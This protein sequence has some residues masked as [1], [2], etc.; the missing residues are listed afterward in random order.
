MS[1]SVPG[2]QLNLFALPAPPSVRIALDG[3]SWMEHH[4]GWLAQDASALFE[5]L[6][7]LPLWE[8]RRRWMFTREV[9]EPR[10]TA[11]FPVLATAPVAEV[12]ELGARLSAQYGVAYDSAWLNLYRTHEDSTAW[13]A[14]RAPRQR[15]TAVV[16]VLS[17]GASRRFFIRPR[18]GGGRS[19]VLAVA[20]GDLVVMGGRCQKDHLHAVPKETQP[21]GPRISINFGTRAQL[22]R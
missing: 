12:S 21:C 15:E 16:P 14:D 3:D 9:P 13:H 6:L 18:E 2:S 7:R 10:L 5:A 22:P 20:S 4:P 11:E 1:R 8:Q 19:T 17:L